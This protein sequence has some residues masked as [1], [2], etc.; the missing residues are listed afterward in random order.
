MDPVLLGVICGVAFA[1]IEVV[2]VLFGRWPGPAEEA[3]VLIASSANRFVTGLIIPNTDIGLT[4]W[5]SGLVIGLLLALPIA[6]VS[7]R[8]VGPLGLGAVGGMTIAALAELAN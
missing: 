6:A 8:T 7:R 2:L 3:R 5:A 1:A 4:L